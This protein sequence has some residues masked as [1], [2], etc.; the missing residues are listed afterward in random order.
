LPDGTIRREALPDGRIRRE[1]LP[2][3]RE[4][5]FLVK[6]RDLRVG[7]LATI[8]AGGLEQNSRELPDS[9]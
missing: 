8:Y 5:F 4:C 6:Y 1:A 3:L 2:V 7:A 9:C